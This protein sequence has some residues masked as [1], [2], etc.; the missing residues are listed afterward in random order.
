MKKLF[1][2]VWALA[3]L[4][5]CSTEKEEIRGIDTENTTKMFNAMKYSTLHDYS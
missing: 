4:A 2:S 5:G 1:I 3:A